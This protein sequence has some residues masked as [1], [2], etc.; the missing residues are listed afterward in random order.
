[1]KGEDD[2]DDGL[3]DVL[4]PNRTAKEVKLQLVRIEKT[5][6]EKR[7]GSKLLELQE[8]EN[9]KFIV[10]EKERVIEMQKDYQRRRRGMDDILG[11]TTRDNDLSQ[12]EEGKDENKIVKASLDQS[13]GLIEETVEQRR[14]REL[15]EALGL[16]NEV[17]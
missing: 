1:M 17:V 7:R 2:V 15:D 12:E 11:L 5:I 9:E 16:L 8:E 3:R 13:L 4:L 6:R 14:K 10:E